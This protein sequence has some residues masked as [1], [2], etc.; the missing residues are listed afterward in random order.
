MA[1]FDETK[2]AKRIDEIRHKEEEE[3]V[4]YMAKKRGALYI[5]LTSVGI[6]TDALKL[7]QEKTARSEEIAAFKIIGDQLH[8]AARSPERSVVQDRIAQLEKDGYHTTVY[9]AST[10]S[11]EKAWNRYEDISMASSTRGSFV[12]ISESALENI[13]NQIHKSEDVK[14]LFESSN[15][16]GTSHRIS[17]LVEIIFGAAIAL[18][19][20][21]IHIEPQDEQVRVRYRMD[22][23]LHDVLFF[24]HETHRMINSR[25]K[26]LSGLM[27]SQTNDAQDG[28]LTIDFKGKEIE[29]RTSVIP[30]G[31]GE[32]IVMRLL[33]PDN[34]NV[35]LEDLGIEPR[36]LEVLKQEIEKPNGLILTTG[37][38]GSGKTTTLYSF[39]KY[40]YTPEIKILTIEDPIEYHV[41]GI[42]QTQIDHEAGY[43]FLSGLRAA[44]RQDPDVV[45]VGEIRDGETAGI[46]VNASLTGHLVLSTLHTNNA[47]GAIPRLLD[48]KVNPGILSAALS[49]SIAQRLVR[50]LCVHCKQEQQPTE[51]EAALLKKVLLQAAQFGKDLAAYN[52]QIDQPI[53]IWKPVGCEKCGNLG[54]KG[55]IG[56]FEAIL[57]DDSIQQILEKHPSEREVK[58]AAAHQGILSMKEDGVLKILSGMTS[59]EEVVKVVDL[60][61]DLDLFEKSDKEVTPALQQKTTL[62][63]ETALPI[64]P[65]TPLHSEDDSE[66]FD[67]QIDEIYAL[68][69]KERSNKTTKEEGSLMSGEERKIRAQEIQHL[70]DYLKML[71]KE[72]DY[73]PTLGIR[74]QVKAVRHTIIDLLKKFP[75]EQLFPERAH[76]QERV[77]TEIKLLMNNLQRLEHE[78]HVNPDV[79][80]ADKLKKI[81]AALENL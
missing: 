80:A 41:Q 79:G 4:Q 17:H 13:T 53:K 14:A 26:L 23:V 77:H 34:I 76:E 54:Y 9:M 39:L 44:L 1:Q 25:I 3:L 66:N 75:F 61:E 31:Y 60:T 65:E 68:G 73:N 81:R 2:Q 69:Q 10:Q 78:Q 19:A 12:D 29:I 62:V 28:R 32:S 71:E 59:M 64:A 11:L 48:L 42:T 63:G 7:I 40:V 74:E 58:K 47:A 33:N 46:A 57:N 36:L 50:K 35:G 37:P 52:V 55:R 5:D 21:D 51:K 45:M 30:G 27:L 38:T 15:V 72:Q 8:I 49:V 56:V 24:D 6:D 70:V 16:D 22:G 43:D 18:K 67:H 20:S